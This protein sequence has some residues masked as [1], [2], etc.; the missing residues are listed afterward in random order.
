MNQRSISRAA[1]L[2][3]LLL[4]LSALPAAACPEVRSGW[5]RVN[6]GSRQEVLL[7]NAPADPVIQLLQ[8]RYTK[9]RFTR[10]PTMNGF[11]LNGPESEV[12]QIRS[13]VP[14]LDRSPVPKVTQ[15]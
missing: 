4:A 8:P 11:Y 13:Q 2:A 6:H 14:A 10:H 3:S 15:P 5:F 1:R 9:V 7:E 12:L